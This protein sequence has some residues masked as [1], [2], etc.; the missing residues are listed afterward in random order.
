MVERF[1]AVMGLKHG[2]A[3]SGKPELLCSL[4][5]YPSLAVGATPGFESIVRA[6]VESVQ[7]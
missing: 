1:G 7:H 3:A 2:D 4:Q 5:T 6:H